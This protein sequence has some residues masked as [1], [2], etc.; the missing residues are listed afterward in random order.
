MFRF[1]LDV[2]KCSASNNVV[3]RYII[4]ESFQRTA[5]FSVANISWKTC[6]RGKTNDCFQLVYIGSRS[7][8]QI[9]ILKGFMFYTD[10]YRHS[11]TTMKRSF[12]MHY[13][14]ATAFKVQT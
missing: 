13:M 12:D 1:F 7:Y 11:H 8:P 4:H 14:H 3:K 9:Q 6:T 2:H 5:V 10:I